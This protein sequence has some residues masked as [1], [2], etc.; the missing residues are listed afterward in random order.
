MIIIIINLE[1]VLKIVSNFLYLSLTFMF[2][3]RAASKVTEKNL[4]V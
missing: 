1:I 2:T 3:L 4:Q